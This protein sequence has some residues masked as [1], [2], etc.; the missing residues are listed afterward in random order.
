MPQ[1]DPASI[2]AWQTPSASALENAAR[3][4]RAVVIWFPREGDSETS[5]AG[6]DIANLSR[7]KALFI[8][9]PYNSDRTIPSWHE[10]S[11]VPTNKLMSDNPSREY[12]VPVRA[13]IVIVADAWGN[14][15]R[16]MRLTST[17]NAR[18]LEGLIDRVEREVENAN[19]GLERTLTRAQ[20]AYEDGNRS[21]ALSQVMRNLNGGLVGLPA[22]E[23][24]ARLYH[25]ILDEAREEVEAAAEA[26]DVDK[27]RGMQREFRNTD[28]EKDIR[29][30]IDRARR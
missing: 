16:G 24:T 13:G 25:R 2:P 20:S 21:Q 27:L 30:A 6:E 10:D 17:P 28:L 9:I 1:V 15:Y 23:E 7:E 11:V 18:T 5:F 22:A 26:G 8:R 12:D 14:E 3:D 19:R 4:G 29:T